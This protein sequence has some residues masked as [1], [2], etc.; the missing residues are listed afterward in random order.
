LY[1]GESSNTP[2]GQTNFYT[3]LLH[4][5]VHTLGIEHS[6][7]NNSIMYAYYKGDIDKLTQDDMWAIQYSLSQFRF[8]AT[9][10]NFIK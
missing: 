4:E 1:F 6:A 9:T 8:F 7:N 3:V 5:I 10:E 2:D